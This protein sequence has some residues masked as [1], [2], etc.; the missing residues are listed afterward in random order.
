MKEP[1]RRSSLPQVGLWATRS[2]AGLSYL[3]RV[4]PVLSRLRDSRAGWDSLVIWV[5]LKKAS[6]LVNISG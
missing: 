3:S 1:H 6:P 5:A 4:H 2:T